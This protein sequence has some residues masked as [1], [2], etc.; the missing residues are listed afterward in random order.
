MLNASDV[1]CAASQFNF[2]NKV[3]GKVVQGLVNCRSKERNLF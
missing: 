3:K 1:L 2:W